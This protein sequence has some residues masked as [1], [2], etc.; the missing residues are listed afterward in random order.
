MDYGVNHNP[1]KWTMS[2]DLQFVSV[3][4]EDENGKPIYSF[5][6]RDQLVGLVEWFKF[7][8]GEQTVEQFLGIDLDEEYT[9]RILDENEYLQMIEDMGNLEK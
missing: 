8:T 5:I 9:A 2:P 3:S 6:H 4:L 7:C 1:V